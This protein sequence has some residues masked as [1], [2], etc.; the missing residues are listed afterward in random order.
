[1]SNSNASLSNKS[2]PTSPIKQQQPI[3]DPFSPGAEV[4]N[5]IDFNVDWS[6]AFDQQNQSKNSTDFGI[7]NDPFASFDTQKQQADPFASFN[8]PENS[9]NDFDTLWSNGTT[10]QKAFDSAFAATSAP[11][12]PKST[13]V[14][15]GFGN[16]DNWAT[17]LNSINNSSDNTNNA[18][19][20]KSIINLT[21]STTATTTATANTN[22]GSNFSDS[23]NV[24][25]TSPG[26]WASFD[27]GIY[28][29]IIKVYF[30]LNTLFGN[31]C[32]YI[33]RKIIKMIVNF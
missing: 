20:T 4:K 15:N 1:M 5:E 8:K 22:F 19:P 26:N 31:I 14:S 25:Q 16:D 11:V 32:F 10:N 13:S 3:I 2:Q 29:Y 9:L 12:I 33:Q 27:Q 6:N 28:I 18:S 24:N 17:A 23:N 21:S 7:E 30:L